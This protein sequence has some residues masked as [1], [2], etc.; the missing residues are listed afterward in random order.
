[1][2]GAQDGIADEVLLLAILPDILARTGQ[3]AGVDEEVV[4][5]LS[6]L[7]EDREDHAAEFDRTGDFHLVRGAGFAFGA[8]FLGC[9]GKRGEGCG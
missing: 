4:L 9:G 6:L 8:V 7:V 5:Q 1:M 3:H 2:G